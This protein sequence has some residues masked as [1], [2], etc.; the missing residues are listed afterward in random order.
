MAEVFEV[1]AMVT[2]SNGS[3]RRQEIRKIG[4]LDAQD[5]EPS[6][7][8]LVLV[9]PAGPRGRWGEMK[10]ES[11]V[12]MEESTGDVTPCMKAFRVACELL[13]EDGAW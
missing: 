5:D 12:I 10:G 6:Q 8:A 9:T 13:E 4:P 7:F 1:V 11:V 3:G 2:E